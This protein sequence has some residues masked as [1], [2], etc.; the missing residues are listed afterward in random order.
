MRTARE[1][2]KTGSVYTEVVCSLW[3][4]S[5]LV[6]RIAHKKNRRSFRS[7][8]TGFANCH[9][10]KRCTANSS[11]VT[12]PSTRTCNSTCRATPL[13]IMETSHPIRKQTDPRH[14][15]GSMTSWCR[16][17]TA[18]SPPHIQF[19]TRQLPIPAVRLEE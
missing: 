18:T 17:K 6:S 8:K 4:S 7:E 1:H 15:S 19:L 13:L 10:S 16:I 14:R 11:T 12:S 2:I 5:A 3:R 9:Q